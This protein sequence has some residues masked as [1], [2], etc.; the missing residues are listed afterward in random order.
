VNRSNGGSTAVSSPN[1]D[2]GGGG[3][4]DNDDHNDLVET[5]L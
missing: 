5:I 2:S 4:D 1:V 3:D